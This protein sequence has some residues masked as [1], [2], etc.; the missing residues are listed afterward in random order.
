[1]NPT[2]NPRRPVVFYDGACPL[3]RREIAHYRRLDRQQRLTWLDIATR[4]QLLQAYDIA[5]EAAMQRLHVI[6]ADGR[7]LTGARAFRELWQHLPGYRWLARVVTLPGMLPVLEQAYMW[8]AHRRWRRRCG[9][10]CAAPHPA[11]ETGYGRDTAP[12]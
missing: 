2:D 7:L 1:M 6:G 3:C 8:F 4:P 9:A 11:P 10:H 5:W 12:R